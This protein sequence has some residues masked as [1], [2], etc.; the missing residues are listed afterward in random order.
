MLAVTFN[1]LLLSGVGCL[2]L[3]Q[4]LIFSRHNLRVPLSK[5]ID[6]YTNKIF[7]K[8][9]QE[10]G[11]LTE[12]GALLEGHMSEYLTKWMRE[13]QLLPGTCPDKETV[14]IYANNKRRTIATAK[15]FVDAAFPDC[16]I[17]V[18]HKKDFDIH[19]IIFN[20]AIHNTTEAYKQKVLEEIE[21]MLANC[22]LTDAYEELDKIIDIKTSKICE[23]Q[24]FCDLVH[25]KNIVIYHVGEEL[26]LNGP[27]RIGN[28][29]VDNFIM[30]YYEGRPLKEVA[31][32]EVTSPEQW[33]VL[34]KIAVKD[35]QMRFNIPSAVKDTARPTIRYMRSIFTN[36]NFKFA[37]LVGHDTNFNILTNALGFNPFVLMEQYEPFPVGG[38]IIFQKWKD[39]AGD[40]YLKVEYVYQSWNQIRDGVK[41][42]FKNPPLR[43]TLELKECAI[44]KNDLCPW[45]DFLKFLN[46]Y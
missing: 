3:E 45:D 22:K 16:N 35:Q 39:V 46:K 21:E 17:N 9:S 10:P 11:M 33:E 13:N 14:L 38:K 2:R 32:G 31:W 18:K 26:E 28:S 41:I 19:D 23:T 7:P 34:T 1:F 8:W 40:Y 12:K 36:E 44:D 29:I 24:R 4:V 43:E 42:N 20:S 30:S 25:D 5:H 27:L 37:L 6:E 15:A